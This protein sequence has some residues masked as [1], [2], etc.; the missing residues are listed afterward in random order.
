MSV[1]AANAGEIFRTDGGVYLQSGH[2]QYAGD[3]QVV[4]CGNPE[5]LVAGHGGR[6]R[7]SGHLSLNGALSR[8]YYGEL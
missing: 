3:D 4:S 8:Q 2:L 6:G 5:Q 1:R 7:G